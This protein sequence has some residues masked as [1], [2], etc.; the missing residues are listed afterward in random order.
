MVY[1]TLQDGTAVTP[2]CSPMD[3][4]PPAPAPAA[5][6]FYISSLRASS[7][8]GGGVSPDKERDPVTKLLRFVHFYINYNDFR[9]ISIKNK[10]K[11]FRV[12]NMTFCCYS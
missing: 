3:S 4:P 10:K 9:Y 6:S 5:P 8:R 2:P 1:Y 11:D 7:R 12:K